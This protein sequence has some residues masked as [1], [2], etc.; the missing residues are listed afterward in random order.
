M[1]RIVE[2]N[3]FELV[4]IGQEKTGGTVEN[5]DLS[6]VDELAVYLVKAGRGR[7]LM[8]YTINEAGEIVMSVDAAEVS[9]GIYG[10]EVIGKIEDTAIHAQQPSAFQIVDGYHRFGDAGAVMSYEVNIVMIYNTAANKRYVDAAVAAEAEARQ[11]ADEALG[12]RIDNA[13]KVDDVLIDG[14]S[15]LDPDTKKANIPTE[16][17]G[18]VDD[19]KV[20]GVSVRDEVT[21]EANINITASVV[22]DD[23]PGTP[24]ANA[25]MQD[26]NI[27]IEFEHVKGERGNG[28]ASVTEE[29]SQEDGGIN[30]HT[31]HYTDPNVPDSVIH[32]R[33]GRQGIQGDSAI[34]DENEP[35]EKLT[36][37][38]HD[39]G[40]STVKPMSQNAVTEEINP[41]KTFVNGVD[42]LFIF[43]QGKY[44]H[45]NPNSEVSSEYSQVSSPKAVK[46]G[47]VV[48]VKTKPNGN[49]FTVIAFKAD[50]DEEYEMKA[51]CETT[52]GSDLMTFT[53]KVTEDGVIRVSGLTDGM[54]AEV[55][56]VEKAVKASDFE[57]LSAAVDGVSQFSGWTLNR[58]M[59]PS[60]G[61]IQNTTKPNKYSGLTTLNKGDVVKVHTYFDGTDL[62][63]VIVS[64]G[65]VKETLAN[66]KKP[67]GYYDFSYT[68]EQETENVRVC[69]FYDTNDSTHTNGSTAYVELASGL[70]KRGDLLSLSTEIDSIKDGGSVLP[71]Y[72]KAYL[73][74]KMPD[75]DVEVESGSDS[76]L[77]ITDTHYSENYGNSTALVSE[78]TRMHPFSKVFHGGDS[79]STG[80]N[81]SNDSVPKNYEQLCI[82]EMKA[83]ERLANKAKEYAR[84]YAVRGN[85]DFNEYN[86]GSKY[87][88][89]AV[90][91]VGQ[92]RRMIDQIGVVD[93]NASESLYYYF[94]NREAK[95]RYIFLDCLDGQDNGALMF[96]EAQM[97]WLANTLNGITDADYKVIVV[98]HCPIT[99][100]F[101]VSY[102]TGRDKFGNLR[103]LLLAYNSKGN[104]TIAGT[105]YDF[106]NA[107][108]EII[109]YLHGHTHVDNQAYHDGIPFVATMCD[110]YNHHSW[111]PFGEDTDLVSPKTKGTAKE[112]ALEAVVVNADKSII[113][114]H[115]IG[116]GYDRHFHVGEI[117][118][119]AG[120][121][122]TLVASVLTPV[123]WTICDEDVM[124]NNA[125]T[126]EKGSGDYDVPIDKHD[127]ATIS[128]ST[129]TGVSAGDVLVFAED[130]N[131]NK[132]FFHIKVVAAQN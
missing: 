82:R 50:G 14:V 56:P 3:S 96:R 72:W 90:E 132:E 121:T 66:N 85:H 18:K 43:T 123:S 71:D 79:C 10:V 105:E 67:A 36:D 55:T 48:T 22:E 89:T 29:L 38:A 124:N 73:S 68:V 17:F 100:Y 34:W 6:P 4:I 99:T 62:Y 106:T 119:Q 20:N 45:Q 102:E 125:A 108:G 98:G 5:I 86:D 114:F 58:R 64:D 13:G 44:L 46:E 63:A 118:V 70:A 130:A 60:S 28:I 25:T 76:F 127:F 52:T 39:L 117:E 131:H 16:M 11:A 113:S 104:V 33:N 83:Y 97:Q 77:F 69:I 78:I 120:S 109:M 128:G 47:E 23:E 112:Q 21:K 59:H 80:F 101:A 51:K 53:W 87:S 7:K 24:T 41:L 103:L 65:S 111:S 2:G 129:V 95:I 8:A 61:D 81:T 32:T 19:V 42:D 107:V 31:I 30:T 57:R 37:L 126:D 9:K 88:H 122:E 92:I 115:R 93:G 35:H 116:L 54:I 12:E 91:S 27:N 40:D 49:I 84:F 26:G 94:D 75:I 74:A 1:H 15:I 110:K